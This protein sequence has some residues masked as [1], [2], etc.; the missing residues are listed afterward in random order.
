[1]QDNASFSAV[2]PPLA[3]ARLGGESALAPNS[4]LSLFVDQIPWSQ[5]IDFMGLIRI[6]D[7]RPSGTHIPGVLKHE[8]TYF[9]AL[10]RV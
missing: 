5:G 9:D 3:T 8:F 2:F 1:M 10:G 6:L 7:I 4:H